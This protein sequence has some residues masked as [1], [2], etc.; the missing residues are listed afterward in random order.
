MSRIYRS[1]I[2]VVQKPTLEEQTK[3]NFVRR[4]ADN[5]RCEAIDCGLKLNALLHVGCVP[6]RLIQ[7]V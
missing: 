6:K 1:G 7:P 4:F 3:G 2:A 5:L